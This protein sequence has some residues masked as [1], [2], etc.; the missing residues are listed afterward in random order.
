M[1]RQN[2]NNSNLGIAKIE[3][4]ADYYSNSWNQDTF[5]PSVTYN[6]T[7]LSVNNETIPNTD[8]GISGAIKNGGYSDIDN[9]TDKI[10]ILGNTGKERLQN[11]FKGTGRP[12][13]VYSSRELT[14]MEDG[15]DVLLKENAIGSTPNT[16][17]QNK[18]TFTTILPEQTGVDAGKFSPFNDM[19]I[20]EAGLFSDA[21]FTYNTEEENIDSLHPYEQMNHGIMWAKK[22]INPIIKLDEISITFKWSFYL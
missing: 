22:Y 20:K 12:V 7:D 10:Q 1:N 8:T 18:I 15:A 2:I 3:L 13:F 5:N 21:F 9:R 17:I 4:R 16:D 14:K 19:I 11:E 6:D